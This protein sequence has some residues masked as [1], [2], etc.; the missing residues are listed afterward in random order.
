MARKKYPLKRSKKSASSASPK[1]PVELR[2]LEA[3]GEVYV[4]SYK[5]DWDDV[6]PG[7]APGTRK[8]ACKHDSCNVHCRASKAGGPPDNCP[9][10]GGPAL[11]NYHGALII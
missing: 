7:D 1:R 10:E 6:G 9:R 11:K 8:Y 5:V 3:K 4:P 2:A